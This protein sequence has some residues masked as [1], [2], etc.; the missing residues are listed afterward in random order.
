MKSDDKESESTSHEE[1]SS[2]IA[3]N[4][5]ESTSDFWSDSNTSITSTD[6]SYDSASESTG[7]DND[8]SDT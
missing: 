1:A 6:G 5:Y 8:I 3:E 7:S 2:A 4:V